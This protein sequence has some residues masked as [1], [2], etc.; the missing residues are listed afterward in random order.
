MQWSSGTNAGYHQFSGFIKVFHGM[1][2][3]EE[4]KRCTLFLLENNASVWRK[5]KLWAGVRLE[6]ER[7]RKTIGL[8]IDQL[9][10]NGLLHASRHRC[11]IQAI[12]N[13]GPFSFKVFNLT[14][15]LSRC[16]G[17][18]GLIVKHSPLPNSLVFAVQKLHCEWADFGNSSKVILPKHAS[19][20]I[21]AQAVNVKLPPRSMWAVR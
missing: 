6:M 10:L 3:C 11:L 13:K 7:R 17:R 1:F 4:W 19:A 21:D 20:C 12:T 8:V 16:E 14:Q 5:T 9:Y 15:W 2:P 18:C